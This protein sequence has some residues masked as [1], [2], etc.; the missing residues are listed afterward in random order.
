MKGFFAPCRLSTAHSIREA[1]QAQ[2]RFG[3]AGATDP[4]SSPLNRRPGTP[5]DR[6]GDTDDDEL[7]CMRI[8]CVGLQ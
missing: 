5:I 6:V 1:L 7:P 8:A 2:S 4:S 3:A